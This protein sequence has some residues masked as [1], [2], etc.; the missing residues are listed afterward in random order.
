MFQITSELSP[1]EVVEFM[2]T[3]ASSFELWTTVIQQITAYDIMCEILLIN[4]CRVFD[5]MRDDPDE[6]TGIKYA[7]IILTT[8]TL[9]NIYT[10]VNQCGDGGLCS[11]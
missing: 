1:T 11:E 8:E 5:K 4:L 10:Q 2:C 6:T 3:D 7:F 9:N